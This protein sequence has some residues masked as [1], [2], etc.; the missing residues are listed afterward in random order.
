MV[1]GDCHGGLFMLERRLSPL[2]ILCCTSEG[3]LGSGMGCAGH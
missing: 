2:M 1:S 3:E